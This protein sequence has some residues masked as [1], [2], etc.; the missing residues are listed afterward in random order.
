MTTYSVR[1]KRWERGWELHIDGVGV[2]QFAQPRR[3]REGVSRRYISMTTGAPATAFS[4][5]IVPEMEEGH[6]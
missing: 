3:G 5:D 6:S 4:V 1:A 2:T